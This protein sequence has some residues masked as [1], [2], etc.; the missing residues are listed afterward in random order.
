MVRCLLLSARSRR[1]FGRANSWPL[2]SR[3]LTPPATQAGPFG[4]SFI[5]K[6]RTSLPWVL[7]QPKRLAI[8]IG[9]PHGVP[10][11]CHKQQIGSFTPRLINMVSD[12]RGCFC[13]RSG[14][15][16]IVEVVHRVPVANDDLVA[17]SCLQ[18]RSKVVSDIQ[19]IS[20]WG[21]PNPHLSIRDNFSI[22]VVPIAWPGHP[23]CCLPVLHGG[24]GA[25]VAGL[26]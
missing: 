3:G 25:V 20:V 17:G 12:K 13:N 15:R 16:P 11:H 5:G 14:S 4:A 8:V 22:R 1:P 21:R 2:G 24:G 26:D 10:I 19:P 23:H 18:F 6:L 7:G 9:D